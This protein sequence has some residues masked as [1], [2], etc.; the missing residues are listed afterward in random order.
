M[1]ATPPHSATRI[2]AADARGIG[3]AAALL[4]EG[5]LVAFPTETVY[6]LGANALD[7]R[8]VAAIFA[9][10]ERPR[11]NPLIVHVRDSKEA[12][13][14]VMFNRLAA[15][16]AEAFWPG[17]LTLVLPRREPSPL[18]L[19]VSAGL[20]TVAL[21]SPAHRVARALIEAAGVPIAAPSANRAGR[22]S[23]TRAEAAADEL[24]GRVDVVLDGGPCPLGIESTIIGFDK[25][26]PVLLR[27]GAV[28]REDLEKLLGPLQ[29]PG[30]GIIQAPGMMASHYAPRAVLRLNA[31]DVK[32][33]EAL[34]AFGREIPAGSR[35][36]L[37]LSQSGDVRE[38]A[39]N[40][41]AMLREL[42]RSGASTIAVMP[43]PNRGLGEAINDRLARAAA[44]RQES[45]S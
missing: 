12:G 30:S 1:V 16:L 26:R 42:D 22:I 34:L 39:A 17:G 41:F 23:P 20:G 10:K 4:R 5:R 27:P 21:R 7:G 19:L 37:N 38:A 35:S 33:G 29:G 15:S 18:A 44:P 14:L 11:F 3:Q 43:I 8:A 28:L 36:V 32:Q 31:I 40:L 45:S 24:Q 6:G 25:D 9:A 13:E 2:V